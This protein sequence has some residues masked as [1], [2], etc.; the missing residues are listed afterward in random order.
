MAKKTEQKNVTPDGGKMPKPLN[1]PK[2]KTDATKKTED[3][4]GVVDLTGIDPENPV[5]TLDEPEADPPHP[6]Q[7][8][9]DA[10]AEEIPDD[11]DARPIVLTNI[12]WDA[13]DRQAKRGKMTPSQW[14]RRFL[15]PY[16]RRG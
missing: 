8:A 4:P 6:T 3:A 1:E 7:P 2:G 16:L 10:I 14:L 11:C 9:V 13:I 5:V 12:Q 15:H